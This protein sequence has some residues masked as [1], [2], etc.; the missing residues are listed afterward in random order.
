M[1]CVHK[2]E[3]GP[4]CKNEASL[5]SNDGKCYSH[6]ETEAVAL[7]RKEAEQRRKEWAINSDRE[8]REKAIESALFQARLASAREERL[9]E[10]VRYEISKIHERRFQRWEFAEQTMDDRLHLTFIQNR[11]R[12]ASFKQVIANEKSSHKA[13]IFKA[14]RDS[15]QASIALVKEML[16]KDF[17]DMA[18]V[19]R[20]EC[21]CKPLIVD[22]DWPFYTQEYDSESAEEPYGIHF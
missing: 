20:H 15:P 8:K 10:Q 14:I 16:I 5:R 12:L 7:L 19:D 2:H 11:Q 17:L 13:Q 1:R 18:S 21:R 4:Q 22:D 6:S 9:A 3:R